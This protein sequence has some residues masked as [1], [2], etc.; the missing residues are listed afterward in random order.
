MRRFS[1]AA[2]AHTFSA[3]SFSGRKPRLRRFPSS[4]ERRKSRLVGKT[5]GNFFA[6]AVFFRQ[7]AQTSHALSDR[8][9]VRLSPF[10]EIPQL[11]LERGI[12]RHRQI[13][14]RAERLRARSVRPFR[15]FEKTVV[16]AVVGGE[17]F[18][19]SPH[20]L[21][22]H[23]L[24]LRFGEL[25]RQHSVLRKIFEIP[26]AQ[27]RAF[28]IDSGTQNHRHVVQDAIFRDRFAH[29]P[30]QIP[31]KRIAERGERWDNRRRVPN[32]AFRPLPSRH[33][34]VRADRR[35]YAGRKFL[36]LPSDSDC[37]FP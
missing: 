22:L 3:E 8:F 16:F 20:A 32:T 9:S 24:D 23:S 13:H 6:Q 34:V 15:R 29:A 25:S 5:D 4:S 31:I 37:P 18:R 33:T 12:I 30:H 28:Q 1:R 19:G 14:A 10:V 17:V 27:R 11:P 2:T 21:A 26:P 36:R 7:F 35:T